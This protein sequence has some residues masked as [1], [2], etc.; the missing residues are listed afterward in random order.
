M[1]KRLAASLAAVVVVAAALLWAIVWRR[2]RM[3]REFRPP[4]Y[5]NAQPPGTPRSL[6]VVMQAQGVKRLAAY[7]GVDTALVDGKTGT[8]YDATVLVGV[9]LQVDTFVELLGRLSRS[10][11][12]C[13][14]AGAHGTVKAMV[15][16]QAPATQSEAVVVDSGTR[17]AGRYAVLVHIATR[18]VTTSVDQWAKSLAKQA[19]SAAL[20]GIDASLARDDVRRSVTS[21]FNGQPPC[22]HLAEYWSDQNAEDMVKRRERSSQAADLEQAADLRSKGVGQMW[23]AMT[24]AQKVRAISMLSSRPLEQNRLKQMRVESNLQDR[25]TKNKSA[26]QANLDAARA[27]VAGAKRDAA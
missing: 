1:Y 2:R 5:S 6:D 16:M 19:I 22:L 24:E 13:M 18:T 25:L 20:I 27:S 10:A 26:M 11:T 12:F 8:A 15:L 14:P 9:Q 23:S 17:H 21:I 7:N 4:S 3:D